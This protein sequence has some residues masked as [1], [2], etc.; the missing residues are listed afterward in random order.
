[1]SEPLKHMDGEQFSLQFYKGLPPA[2]AG[3]CVFLLDDGSIHA[4]AIIHNSETFLDGALSTTNPVG[5]FHEKLE[6]PL[7]RVIGFAYAGA[8]YRRG[9]KWWRDDAEKVCG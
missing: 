2:F 1:M 9:E 4:G 5:G 8:Q 3:P 7:R 6:I